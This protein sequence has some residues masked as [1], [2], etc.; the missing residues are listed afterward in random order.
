SLLPENLEHTRWMIFLQEAEKSQL[1]TRDA[2]ND[3][4]YGDSFEFIRSYFGQVDTADDLN[5]QLFVD[6]KTYLVDDILVKLDRMTMATSL[7]GR[8][9]FLD[10][11]FVEF[12]ATIPGRLKMKGTDTKHI[13]KKA[14]KGILP[15]EILKRGKEGFSIPIKNWLKNDL[16]E[17]MLD[18][19]SPQKIKQQG[20]FNADYV[21][22]LTQE[23]LTG[24][25]NHSHRLWAMMVFG[26]WH[27]IY[28]GKQPGAYE[29]ATQAPNEFAAV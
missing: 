5:R 8:V 28:L 14:M 7:E 22:R 24:R 15:P 16:K 17:L 13:L 4:N 9:P 21:Q 12:A 6:I 10:Y 25:E 26:I 20:F 2:Q 11:R 1:Y 3:I 19:L 23:H 18:V 27:D 29:K